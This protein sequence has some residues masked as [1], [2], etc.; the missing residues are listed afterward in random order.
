MWPR[1]QTKVHTIGRVT[2]PAE[3]T[4]HRR[5]RLQ[6]TAHTEEQ[7]G[8]TLS[9]PIDSAVHTVNAQ[10]FY[11]FDAKFHTMKVIEGDDVS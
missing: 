10:C 4:R 3:S 9:G 2:V 6:R 7:D 8:I 5:Q 11:G 1:A